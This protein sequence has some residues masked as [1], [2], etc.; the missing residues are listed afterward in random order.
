MDEDNDI[1]IEKSVYEVFNRAKMTSA[2]AGKKQPLHDKLHDT[3][4]TLCQDVHTSNTQHMA[5]IAALNHF[6]AFDEK[7]AVSIQD[8]IKKL[9]NIYVTALALKFNKAY[10]HIGYENRNILN[11]EIL[12]DFRQVV[13]NIA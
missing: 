2:F 8:I 3:Y 10:H 4:A 13:Q 1:I 11:K 12:K 7:E 5:S 9:S 6:P